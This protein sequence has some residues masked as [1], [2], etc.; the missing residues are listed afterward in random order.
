MLFDL[1][2]HGGV[3]TGDLARLAVDRTGQHE[4]VV[5]FLLRLDPGGIECLPVVGDQDRLRST[6]DRIAG[7]G[8]FGF[9]PLRPRIQV[10]DHLRGQFTP[11]AV[12]FK[13]RQ[14]IGKS[15]LVRHRGAR[16]DDVERVPDDV[17]KDQAH[18][19][20]GRGQPGQLSTFHPRDML[21]D[22][23][24]L[25]DRRAALQQQFRDRLFLLERHPFCRQRHERGSTTRKQAEH[26]IVLAEGR[27]EPDDLLRSGHARRVRHGM[28]RFDHLHAPQR[29]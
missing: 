29:R 1:P 15:A 2:G 21:A 17:R 25:V 20:R 7:T 14:A 28:A 3:D 10:V 6:E 22:R 5:P 11:Q 19:P 16:R 9:G 27:Q 23:I 13:Y 18:Q 12:L 8:R 24:G 4:R 26:Q